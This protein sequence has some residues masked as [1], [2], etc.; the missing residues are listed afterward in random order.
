MTEASFG[1]G[2]VG[3]RPADVHQD[4]PGP[5]C[6]RNCNAYGFASALPR[7]RPASSSLSPVLPAARQAAPPPTAG[8]PLPMSGERIRQRTPDVARVQSTHAKTQFPPGPRRQLQQDL[9]KDVAG[10]PHILEGA[11]TTRALLILRVEGTSPWCSQKRSVPPQSTV[12]RPGVHVV[13]A[14]K[15]LYSIDRKAGAVGEAMDAGWR[16]APRDTRGLFSAQRAGPSTRHRPF[17]TWSW[18]SSCQRPRPDAARNRIRPQPGGPALSF[19]CSRRR[20]WVKS[21]PTSHS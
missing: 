11:A 10:M 2:G 19:E 16:L 3:E 4:G 15:P 13:V 17:G 1:W 21:T 12:G 6:D 18:T 20:R 8:T 9:L 7:S 14:R 5:R